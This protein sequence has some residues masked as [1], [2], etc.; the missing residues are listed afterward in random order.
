MDKVK[1]LFLAIL[2]LAGALRFYGLS[3]RSLHSDEAVHA[4]FTFEL[5][6]RYAYDPI[7]HGPFLYHITALSFAALGV[8]PFSLRLPQ[9]LFGIGLIALLWPLRKDQYLG[10]I[11]VLVSALLLAV[12]PSF[13]YYSRFAI[14][15]SFFAFFTLGTIVSCILYSESK[16]KD[17]VYL[18]LAAAMLALLFTVKENAYLVAAIFAVSS[19]ISFGKPQLLLP[20]PKHILVAC[21][22]FAFIF[23]F[24]YSSM[25]RNPS[26]LVQGVTAPVKTWLDKAENWTGHQKPAIYYVSLLVIYE[27][28]I[29]IFGMAGTAKALLERKKN[30]FL[31]F[32]SLWALFTIAVYFLMKYKTPWLIAHMALP[33]ALMAGA[34]AEKTIIRNRAIAALFILTLAFSAIAMARVNFEKS[35]DPAEPL[36]YVQT[37]SDVSRLVKIVDGVALEKKADEKLTISVVST[38]YWPLPF[39]FRD[40]GAG[41]WT[42]DAPAQISADV[43]LSSTA[44]EKKVEDILGADYRRAGVFKLREWYG[45]GYTTEKLYKFLLDGSGYNSTGSFDL[46]LYLK[47]KQ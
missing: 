3:D 16:K 29:L 27:L 40:Y 2:L 5:P 17:P 10:K 18:Y 1:A 33:L 21:L 26:S 44:N 11:G 25:F 32:T 43:V 38:D 37:S 24:F 47:G 20:K 31:F 36:V 12:S 41:Y 39:Y 42:G 30:R 28:P 7:Y 8:S 14:H 19:V 34:F 23:A 46:V 15:D 4:H 22:I 35:A 45:A 6:T 13:V 9:V